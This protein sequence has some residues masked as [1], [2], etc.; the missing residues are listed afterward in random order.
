[1]KTWHC[2]R[3]SRSLQTITNQQG[4]ITKTATL[5]RHPVTS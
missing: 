4:N 2:S 5:T 1:V 3:D